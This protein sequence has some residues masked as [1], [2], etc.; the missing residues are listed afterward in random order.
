[1]LYDAILSQTSTTETVAGNRPPS[2]GF[3]EFPLSPA[4]TPPSLRRSG[5]VVLEVYIRSL[6]LAQ[7]PSSVAPVEPGRQALLTAFVLHAVLSLAELPLQS[8]VGLTG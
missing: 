5:L 4:P 3:L 6:L 2:A 7:P 1:M 8:T